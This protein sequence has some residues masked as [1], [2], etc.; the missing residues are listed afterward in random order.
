MGVLIQLSVLMASA[1][2][3]SVA[4][5]AGS[6][7]PVLEV[8]ASAFAFLEVAEVAE[9]AALSFSLVEVK[10]TASEALRYLKGVVAE[11]EEEVA[12]GPFLTLSLR[13]SWKRLLRGWKRLPL[14]MLLE[15]A[16]L[17]SRLRLQ[18]ETVPGAPRG[19]KLGAGYSTRA[20]LC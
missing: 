1:R 4:A 20:P 9:L 16:L 8:G 19:P 6:H 13:R 18:S 7:I 2:V 12:M 15:L 5:T 3:V 17:L 11:V 10:Q 14:E